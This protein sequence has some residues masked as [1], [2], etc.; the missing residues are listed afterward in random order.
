MTWIIKCILTSR[1]THFVHAVFIV[2]YYLIAN[3]LHHIVSSW[4]RQ[5][6][7]YHIYPCLLPKSS[8]SF[9]KNIVLF[10]TDLSESDDPIFTFCSTAQC[11]SWYLF[12][13]PCLIWAP[14]DIHK[15]I[16]PITWHHGGFPLLSR[17][18]HAASSF[19]KPG[20]MF[21]VSFRLHTITIQLSRLCAQIFR[22][23]SE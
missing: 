2:Q 14:I 10:R 7:F 12:I 8:C 21:A 16:N 3:S 6:L 15:S 1:I 19:H 5:S 17:R 23:H 20:I 11:A 9:S 13:L 4:I 22:V 18:I